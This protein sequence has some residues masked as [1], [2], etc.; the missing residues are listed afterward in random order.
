MC[1]SLHVLYLIHV[2]TVLNTRVYSIEYTH[3]QYGTPLGANA[4]TRMYSYTHTQVL[5]T[6]H[7]SSTVD[8]NK[9]CF[10]SKQPLRS[11]Y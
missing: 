4:Y 10:V 5:V 8:T 3:V 2:C 6:L 11:D 7:L 1:A 9:L